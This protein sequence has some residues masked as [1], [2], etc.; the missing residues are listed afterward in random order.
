MN[1]FF[2]ILVSAIVAI[3][4]SDTISAQTWIARGYVVFGEDI[5]VGNIQISTSK[6]KNSVKTDST[7]YFEIEVNDKDRLLVKHNSP[8]A[9]QSYSIRKSDTLIYLTVKLPESLSKAESA[10]GYGYISEKYRTAVVK[11][12]KAD[13][14][15]SHYTDIWMIIKEKF[16]NVSINNGCVV[17]RGPGSNSNNVCAM[18]VV[19]GLQIDKIDYLQPSLIKEISLLKDASS[20]I[21]GLEGANG[22]ILIS[23]W[24]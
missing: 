11:T 18:F 8:F 3:L 17:V 9:D 23:T 2:K 6:T 20:S 19:D 1:R 21:Y 13:K 5:P 16:S 7:G 14:D 10:I 12:V 15:F 22:V 4:F 24:K